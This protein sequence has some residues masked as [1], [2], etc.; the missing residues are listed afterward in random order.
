MSKKKGL[1]FIV[2]AVLSV[3]ASTSIMALESEESDNNSNDTVTIMEDDELSF[4]HDL[5]TDQYC[6]YYYDENDQLV[7]NV[8]DK[9]TIAQG[10]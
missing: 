6:G 2:A 1:C 3:S 4:L 10:N 9:S 7:I 8:A 5:P